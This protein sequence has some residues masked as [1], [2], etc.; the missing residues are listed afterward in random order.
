[1]KW[2]TFNKN[3]WP[4]G[5]IAMIALLVACT[6]VN[7]YEKLENIPGAKWQQM[8]KMVFE[9]EVPDSTRDYYLMASIRHTGAYPYK[10]I[11]VRLG[12]QQPGS[13]SVSYQDFDIP[14][15]GNDAWLGVGMNDVY[16]RRVR[17]FRHPVRFPAKGRAVFTLEHI[18][19]DEA[20]PGILQAGIRIEPALVSP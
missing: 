15:A 18:M 6:Q 7:L 8:E 12:L 3:I 9:I 14:L 20:L 10:N 16:D 4:F 11:W 17:L 2:F 1:M 13:D 5:V 19:R